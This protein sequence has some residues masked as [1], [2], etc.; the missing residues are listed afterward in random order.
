MQTAD[1][2]LPFVNAPYSR[3]MFDDEWIFVSG[4]IGMDYDTQTL[5]V[6]AEDQ[7]RLMVRNIEKYLAACGGRLEQV[8]NYTL[9]VAGAEHLGAV[10]QTLSEVLP[11]KPTGTAM[12]AGIAVPKAWVE[13]QV[14]AR[15]S[16]PVGEARS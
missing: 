14:I 11:C 7:T 10:V 4:T 1:F 15:K 16:Q 9:I 12:L 6:S 2:P 13:M 3:A 5:A 8:I